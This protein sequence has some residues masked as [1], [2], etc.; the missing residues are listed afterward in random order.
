MLMEEDIAGSSR[1]VARRAS[2]FKLQQCRRPRQENEIE[3]KG[4]NGD[5]RSDELARNMKLQQGLGDV[6]K[7]DD[8]QGNCRG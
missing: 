7:E 1:N 3:S 6:E 8:R 4:E 5:G 2:N